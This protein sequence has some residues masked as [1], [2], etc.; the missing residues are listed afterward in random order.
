MCIRITWRTYESTHLWAPPAEFGFSRSG[1]DPR[2]CISKSFSGNA[3]AVGPADHILR[4]AEPDT[5]TPVWLWNRLKY[6]MDDEIL[7]PLG[8]I[9]KTMIPV[10]QCWP[11]VYLSRCNKIGIPIFTY[12]SLRYLGE[13]TYIAFNISS[14]LS[15]LFFTSWT[16]KERLTHLPQNRSPRASQGCH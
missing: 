11:N 12:I 1:C 13:P 6:Q 4:T 14:T 10:V 3:V 9:S 5:H 7:Q 15:V 8:S 2:I 16:F